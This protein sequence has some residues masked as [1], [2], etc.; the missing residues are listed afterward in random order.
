[1][2]I[3]NIINHM[4]HVFLCGYSC[5]LSAS[6]HDVHNLQDDK[7]DKWSDISFTFVTVERNGM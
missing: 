7:E 3:L 2:E 4:N 5:S 6:T 1:M